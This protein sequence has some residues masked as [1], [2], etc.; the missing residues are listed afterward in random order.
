MNGRQKAW[1]GHTISSS[2]PTYKKEGKFDLSHSVHLGE[3]IAL[4]TCVV[5]GLTLSKRKQMWFSE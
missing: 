1:D 3:T 5:P 2:T 4:A